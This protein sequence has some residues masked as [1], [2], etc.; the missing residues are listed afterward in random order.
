MKTTRYSAAPGDIGHPG[1]FRN[2]GSGARRGIEDRQPR[3]SDPARGKNGTTFDADLMLSPIVQEGNRTI[4]IVCSLRDITERKQLEAKL[5]QTLEREMQLGE[6]RARF[7]SMASHEFRN[8]LASIQLS[9]DLL[10]HYSDRLPEERKQKELDQIRV[11]IKNMTE[12]L[13]DVL[14]VGTAEAGKLRFE[15][16]ALDVREF[17]ESVL[18]ELQRTIGADHKFVFFSEGYCGTA[19]MDPKLLRHILGN[20]LSNAIKYSPVGSTIT[21]DLICENHQALFRIKDE[22]IGIPEEDQVRLFETFHRAG[23]V[24]NIPGTG[25]GLAIAKQSVDLHGG[26]IELQSVKGRGSTFTVY[27]PLNDSGD[28]RGA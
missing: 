21:F 6:L 20:L 9:A 10:G 1:R 14:L 12:L 22:G 2:P 4:G 27:L 17:C 13:D 25:L 19:S 8:P 24:G 28:T 23:N 11:K 7:V 5:R 16:K 3:G 26:R 15:P 18:I